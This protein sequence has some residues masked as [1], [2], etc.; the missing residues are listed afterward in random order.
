MPPCP[1]TFAP[2]TALVVLR[3]NRILKLAER[4]WRRRLP[5]FAIALCGK[6]LAVS[7][8]PFGLF[9]VDLRRRQ[10]DGRIKCRNAGAS[11]APWRRG[12][13]SCERGDSKAFEDFD[14]LWQRHR[15]REQKPRTD[16]SRTASR[17]KNHGRSSA[18]RRKGTV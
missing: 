4:S 7:A 5:P 1:S 15:R 14:S 12:R 13:S 8:D 11:G 9:L 6:V 2:L 18:N 10:A 16:L 3:G 17:A